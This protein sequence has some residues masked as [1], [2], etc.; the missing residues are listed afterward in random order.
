MG[1]AWDA[2]EHGLKSATGRNLP[3]NKKKKCLKKQ[4]RGGLWRM[5]LADF[6]SKFTP[7]VRPIEIYPT[8]LFENEYK[9]SKEITR[10]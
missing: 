10:Q 1:F 3:M 8:P 5:K 9:L 6:L 4:M 2:E 7:Y